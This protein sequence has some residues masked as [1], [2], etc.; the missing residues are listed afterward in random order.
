[1]KKIRM[2]KNMKNI[3]LIT[4]VGGAAGTFIIKHLQ[5]NNFKV[6]A[7]DSNPHS[8]G[9]LCGD[10]NIVVPNCLDESYI[11]TI[12]NICLQ[13]GISFILPLIDEELSALKSL[14]SDTLKVIC[15]TI[16]FVNL[17]LD[18]FSLMRE[19]SSID[20]FVPE[21]FLLSENHAS[22]TFPVVIKPR[23]GRG[24]R[25]VFFARNADELDRIIL[26]KKNC[27][28]DFL[29][30]K[31]IEGDEY[32]VSVVVNPDNQLIAVVPKKII[33]KKGITKAAVTE[34]NRE[35]SLLCEK[36][37]KFLTPSNP[38]NVQLIVN[39]VDK[40]SYVFEINPRYSTTVTLTIK[41]GVDEIMTAINFYIKDDVEINSDFKEG[42]VLLRENL[43]IFIDLHEYEKRTGLIQRS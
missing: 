38:F 43:E 17:C 6:V 21:T 29:I 33:E 32:T 1:M 13:E 11:P 34:S 41:A 15:P 12:R 23:R 39:A 26:L 35:I 7:V 22:L 36:I 3:I 20:V 27:L 10:I 25:D 14:E 37:V 18:K 42:V 16:K 30:Q 31:K 8:Y 28:D 24:S 19:L 5:N 4:G 40:K 9:L 2:D